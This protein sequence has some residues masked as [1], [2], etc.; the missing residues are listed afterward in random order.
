MSTNLV[1]SAGL[2]DQLAQDLQT[3]PGFARVLVTAC[4]VSVLA[5]VLLNFILARQG[6]AVR[7]RKKSTVETG[8]MLLF[9][10]GFYALIRTRTGVYDVPAMYHPAAD[11][12]LILLLLGTVVNLMGR[13]ALGRNW[14]HHVVIYEDHQLVTRGVYHFVRHPLYAGLI[15]MFLGA[16]LI[17]QNGAALLATLMADAPRRILIMSC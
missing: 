10:A 5:A 14:G 8:S 3:F 1:Q 9:L 2:F 4:T 17:F 15:W 16:A 13:F 11:V 7:S 12:G 6:H